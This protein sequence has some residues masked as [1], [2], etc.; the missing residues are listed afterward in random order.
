MYI[1]CMCICI[2]TVCA[3][4]IDRNVKYNIYEFSCTIIAICIGRVISAQ[5]NPVKNKV[6]FTEDYK[7]SSTILI[8]G[9]LVD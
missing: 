4:E 5:I 7:A 6:L 8:Q 1:I 3:Y 9:W 2:Y